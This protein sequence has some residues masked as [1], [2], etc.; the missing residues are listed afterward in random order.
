MGKIRGPEQPQ[1]ERVLTLKSQAVRFGIL[2][3]V[4]MVLYYLFG[5]Y[6][7]WQN[8]EARLYYSG[9]TE[10]TSMHQR[11]R[12]TVRR[13]P[14]RLPLQVGRGL[15]YALFAYFRDRML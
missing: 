9:A 5:S 7:A 14:S 15:L 13:T 8:P 6:V 11:M 10:I 3:I 1:A 12:S 2:A 4:Y